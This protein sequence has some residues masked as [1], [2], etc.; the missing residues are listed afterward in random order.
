MKKLVTIVAVILISLSGNLLAAGVWDNSVTIVGLNPNGDWQSP[1]EVRIKIKTKG[2]SGCEVI[3][4]RPGKGNI[5]NSPEG[6]GAVNRI[7]STA[8]A[9]FMSEKKIS[10]WVYDI[11]NCF[12]LML[13]I[14]DTGGF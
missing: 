11:P 6:I 10:I 13:V 4:F 7:Y 12:G 5:Q 2:G 1:I 14:G 9:A 3:K 8:L